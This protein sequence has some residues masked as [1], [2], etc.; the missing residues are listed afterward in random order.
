MNK[1]I[2]N[3]I[4]KYDKIMIFRHEFADPDALGSQFGLKELILDNFANKEV[5]A[6]GANV[7]SLNGLLFPMMDECSDDIIKESLVIVLDTANTQRIDDKRYQIGKEII[8]IDHHPSIEAYG[9]YN[10]IDESICATSFFIARFAYALE[11]KMSEVSATY[12]YAG[13][14]GDTG[15][16]LHNNTTARVFE[17]AAALIR[18]GARI[19]DVYDALY[20]RSIA[21]V[22]LTGY[23]LENFKI[24][25]PGLAY[26]LLEEADYL[27]L[28]VTFDKA[29]EYVNTLADIEG[30]KIWVSATFNATT[31]F[32]HLSVRSKDITINDVAQRFGGGG[33]K[34]AA[35]IKTSSLER[36][37]L[38][39]NE[40]SEKL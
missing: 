7:K 35:G 6:L 36:F 2:F 39:L 15:R 8:K 27:A 23:I 11:L 17:M 9:K 32:Y 14:V 19:K 25:K 10:Y 31:G 30:I 1:E 34:H 4:K 21:E 20:S 16:F 40:L 28:G 26:Y 24:V 37:N 38:I 5:Y 33:H 18:S 3:V 12:L 13:L 29:K 22:K